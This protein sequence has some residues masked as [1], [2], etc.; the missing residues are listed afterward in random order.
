MPPLGKTTRDQ[1]REAACDAFYEYGYHGASVREIANRRG[2]SVAA[3]YYHYSSKE[4]VLADV[5]VHLVQDVLQAVWQAS[6]DAGDMPAAK[7]AAAVRTHV[8]F[9]IEHRVEGFVAN[10]E[11]RYLSGEDRTL[12]MEMQRRHQRC[13]AEI[14]E[15]GTA[16]GHFDVAAS[17]TTARA[18][19]SMCTAVLSWYVKGENSTPDEIAD[20]YAY[21]A[22]KLAGSP[23]TG[24]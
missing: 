19:M 16:Q 23:P 13:Y 20:T 11:F 1:V 4:D 21:L 22:L 12:A 17:K 14:L 7:L 6:E 3:L 8:L 15:E 10:A 2:V 5:V 24:G 18:I 9:L